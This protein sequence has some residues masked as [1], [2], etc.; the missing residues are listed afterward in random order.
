[1]FNLIKK[2]WVYVKDKGSNLQ[3]YGYA[4]NLIVSCDALGMFEPFVELALS[5][6][7]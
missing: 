3:T 5:K 4:L 7:C 6:L 1:M 2:I